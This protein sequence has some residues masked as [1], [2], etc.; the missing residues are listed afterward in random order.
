MRGV[1]NKLAVTT[2]GAVV[3]P[4]QPL[5]DIVPLDDALLIE[6][7]IRPKDVAFIRP[8]QRA[9][10]KFTA[11]DFL[12]YGASALRLNIPRMERK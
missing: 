9:T 10:T 4:G 1:V 12:I 7:R 8:G 6:T 2:I 3:Q 5:A 11:Y